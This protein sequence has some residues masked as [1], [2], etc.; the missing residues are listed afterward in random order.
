MNRALI[1]HCF[2][3]GSAVAVAATTLAAEAGKDPWL[4]T[5]LALSAVLACEAAGWLWRQAYPLRPKARRVIQRPK[6]PAQKARTTVPLREARVS[7]L[8]PGEFVQVQC[9]CGRAEMLTTATLAA[10]GVPPQQ[11]MFDLGRQ[12]R[13]NACEASG[14]AMV[15]VTRGKL[16]GVTPTR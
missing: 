10:A 7:D 9:V 13:C 11:K 16:A 15:S 3:A 5:Y 8:G 2:S 4:A 14:C 12:M 6:P 1:N